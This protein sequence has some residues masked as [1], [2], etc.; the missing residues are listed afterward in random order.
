MRAVVNC[1]EQKPQH[2]YSRIQKNDDAKGNT[3]I[4]MTHSTPKN[5]NLG[6][7][8][9]PDLGGKGAG[10][11]NDTATLTKTRTKTKRPNM[12]RVLLLNDDYTPMEFVVAV[13]EK[14]FSKDRDDAT[15]VMLQVHQHGVGECGIFTFEIAET[16]V[17]QVMDFSLKHQHPLQCVMEKNS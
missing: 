14:F 4:F 2:V 1:N 9:N 17:T 7:A 11:S 8:G 12:Y 5:P 15:R 13:L 6:G 16:K 3:E 10:N